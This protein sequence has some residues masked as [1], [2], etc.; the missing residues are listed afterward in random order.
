[1]ALLRLPKK[2]QELI[3]ALFYEEK[4]ERVY[5]E[6]IGVSPSTVHRRRE[7]IMKK[8]EKLFEIA[9]QTSHLT[10]NKVRGL[11]MAA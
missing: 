4:T 2:D 3:Y 7:K 8:I 1:M 9:E 5:A 11:F 6:Q 10:A